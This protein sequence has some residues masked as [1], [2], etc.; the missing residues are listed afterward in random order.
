LYKDKEKE[1]AKNRAYYA[2]NK[3]KIQAYKK[4]WR[5]DN[6]EYHRKYYRVYRYGLKY[7]DFLTLVV[8][9]EGLCA[10]CKVYGGEDLVIDHDHKTNRVRGLLC[11][12]CNVGLGIF[13]DSTLFLKEA[14]IYLQGE[15]N[16]RT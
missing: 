9:Q 6:L 2:R 13:K 11:H 14:I 7:T 1:R 16:G 15:E 4:R 8:K 3:E 10:I 5:K 12:S